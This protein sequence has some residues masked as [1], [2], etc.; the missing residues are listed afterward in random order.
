MNGRDIPGP[1][2]MTP[3][4]TPWPGERAITEKYAGKLGLLLALAIAVPA[5]APPAAAQPLDY[6]TFKTRVEPIFLEKRDD[7]ARCYACHSQSNN[8]FHLERLAPGA[9]FWTEE[10]SQKNFAGIANVVNPADPMAS[11]LLRHPL[12]PEVGGDAF[13]AGG[14]QFTSEH[15]PDWQILAEFVGGPTHASTGK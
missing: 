12:A 14:R 7:H 9:S 11:P 10:Q 15:D 5:L 1:S 3:T 2:A 8:G 13:H 6:Q 4:R